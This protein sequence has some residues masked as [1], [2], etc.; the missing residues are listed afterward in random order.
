M[1]FVHTEK[2]YADLLA[3]LRKEIEDEQSF[4]DAID[5]MRP[6]IAQAENMVADANVSP[7]IVRDR[8]TEVE[9]AIGSLLRD[10]DALRQKRKAVIRPKETISSLQDA[11]HAALSK[12]QDRETR[13]QKQILES[14][15]RLRKQ[16]QSLPDD[17]AQSNAALLL[18]EA[19]LDKLPPT[20]P[21]VATLRKDAELARKR[22]DTRT[23]T[24]QRINEQLNE[25]GEL[26]EASEAASVPPEAMA[27]KKGKG[28]KKAQKKGPDASLPRRQDQLATL[29]SKAEQIQTVVLQKLEPL[30]EEL[31][32]ADLPH[33]PLEL[34]RA[35]AEEDLRQLQ[36][37]LLT[38]HVYCNSD[39]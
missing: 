7:T 37:I 10:D 27:K 19:E 13:E 34:L 14:A 24:Y 6:T 22:L 2:Q 26:L 5:N 33:E 32:R 18:L 30:Q 9:K 4:V 3:M 23:S 8:L 25:L 11:Y 12:L 38:M 1:D 15:G 39:N 31:R 17:L 16:L 20:E 29:R 36:V 21:E 35:R 28:R